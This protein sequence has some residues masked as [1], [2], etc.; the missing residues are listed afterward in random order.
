MRARVNLATNPFV[1]YRRFALTAGILAAVALGLTVLL[2]S[3]GVSV[4]RE[5]SATR[6]RLGELEAQQAQLAAEQGRL[7][8]ALRAPA[9]QA[10]LE[11]TRFLNQLIEHKSLSWTELFFDLQQRLPRRVRILSLAPKL[12]EDDRLQ[13]ELE[14]G[15]ESARAVIRFVRALE[16]GEKFRDVALR[17]QSH[18]PVTNADA[19]VARVSAIYVRSS[20]E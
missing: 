14:V 7:E 18:E 4:W 2:I 10:L 15:G 3:E 12:G 9:T 6:A 19:V 5:R 1:N 11:R 16:E 20:K 13:V 17:S 8:E